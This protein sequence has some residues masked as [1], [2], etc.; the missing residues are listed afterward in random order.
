MPFVPHTH[1]TPLTLNALTLTEG[2]DANA[3]ISQLDIIKT[4][5]TSFETGR[6]QAIINS[7]DIA[8]ELDK[9]KRLQENPKYKK[10]IPTNGKVRPSTADE[11]IRDSAILN[12]AN[13]QTYILGS[14]AVA[15]LVI[16]S[17]YI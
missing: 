8:T 17:M 14:I 5:V 13:N 9:N 10:Y 12:D 6:N 16:L 15:S 4:N 11:M 1:Y 2:F 7:Y 3:A